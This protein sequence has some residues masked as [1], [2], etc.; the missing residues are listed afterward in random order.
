MKL[1]LA[2]PRSISMP[3]GLISLT[4]LRSFAKDQFRNFLG[5]SADMGDLLYILV[6]ETGRVYHVYHRGATVLHGEQLRKNGRISFAR[7]FSPGKLHRLLCKEFNLDV[8]VRPV[9]KVFAEQAQDREHLVISDLKLPR[10]ADFY[11]VGPS[12]NDALLIVP[13][14]DSARFTSSDVVR[15]ATFPA[16]IQ[17][18]GTNNVMMMIRN[19]ETSTGFTVHSFNG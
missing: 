19:S 8:A 16:A 3:G 9:R 18:T 13:H 14:A 11:L 2:N 17:R 4:V 5:A 12:E 7:F 1:G 10:K 15:I 6:E